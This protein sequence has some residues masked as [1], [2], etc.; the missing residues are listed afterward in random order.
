MPD[1]LSIKKS[2]LPTGYPELLKQL[3]EQIRN[4]QTKAALSVNE[5]MIQ[6]YWN[7][8]RQIVERQDV[9]GWGA[10]VTKK[11]SKD[12]IN[13]FPKMR[14]FS[15]A[16]LRRMKAFYEAHAICA[17]AVRKLE[18]DEIRSFFRIPWGHNIALLQKLSC[19]NERLWYARKTI[20]HGWSRA[21]LTIQIESK[22]FHRQGNATTNFHKTLPSPHSDLAHQA[23][24]DPYAFDFLTM[25]DDALEREL[26]QGLIDHIQQ[27]LVELGAGFAFVGRQF[28]V[29]VEDTDYFLDLLFY[30]YKLRC[31]C[32]IELKTTE[33]KP[34]YAGKMNF[35]LAA[36][37]EQLKHPDDEPTIGMVLCKGKKK[38]TVEYALRMC[39]APIGVSSYETQLL[40]T[41][42]DNLKGS[43]PTIEEIEEEFERNQ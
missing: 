39:Q 37:D 28:P 22:L 40:E 19:N 43:L 2:E 8:G 20:D 15:D 21:I 33:F 17:Q 34:E 31:F 18:E 42:P 38:I 4:A 30:H 6:L 27:F 23:L 13:A 25:G 12:L 32:V 9:E 36:V 11:L 3:K 7:I 41:L 14:G 24:K 26:E 16:N 5:E 29:H 35:Y 1:P 10:Q